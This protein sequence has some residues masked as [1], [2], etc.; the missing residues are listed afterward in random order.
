[1]LSYLILAVTVHTVGAAPVG[2]DDKFRTPGLAVGI[3]TVSMGGT[4]NSYYYVLLVSLKKKVFL[5][6]RTER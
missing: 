5:P 1:M 3:N 4:S 2:R 6:Y